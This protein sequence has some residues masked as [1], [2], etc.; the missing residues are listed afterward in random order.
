VSKSNVRKKPTRRQYSEEFKKDAVQ[1]SLEVGCKVAAQDLG[2]S[3]PT[4]SKWRK[5]YLNPKA[6]PNADAPTYEE[7]L[8]ENRR[9]KKEMN[10]L[11]EV[12]EVLKKSHGI[13]SSDYMRGK[14]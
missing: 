2:I 8:K 11:T 4:L 10:Y 14:K 9:L 7:L 1:F 3:E 6:P 13:F 5:K 12:S